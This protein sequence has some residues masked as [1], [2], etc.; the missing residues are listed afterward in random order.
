MN[1]TIFLNG[2]DW[3]SKEFYGEDLCYLEFF[4]QA[5]EQLKEMTIEQ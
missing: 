1:R 3:P 2:S 5:L 4:E